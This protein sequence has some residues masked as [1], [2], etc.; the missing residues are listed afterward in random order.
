MN[1]WLEED[2]DMNE[3]VEI[4]VDDDAKLIFPYEVKGGQIPP[5]RDES[6][7]SE[8]PNAESSDSVS[9][10]SEL[11]DEVDVEPEVDV[12]PEATIGTSTEKPYAIR[13]FLRGL[14]EVGESSST[15]DL[16]YVGG[17]APWA[18]RRDLD[19]TRA[20]ARLT[21]A[22]LGTCQ[23][24][25]ALLKSK[26]KIEEKERE[27]LNHDLENVEHA[28]GNVLERVSVLESGEN[29]T[30]KKKLDE[31]E[32]KLVWARMER[33]IAERSLHESRVWNKRFYLDMV[34][35][36]AVPKPPSDKEDTERPRKKSNKS[37]SDGTEGPSE[38]RGPPS[39]S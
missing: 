27:I 21:E 7:D 3:D 19:A 11:E 31:T 26:D 24:E 25:I 9:S 10:N 13:N 32:T 8:P 15:R 12:A 22:E 39:D 37:S 36:G 16:S 2:D 30:L 14:Y 17:L 6:S 38:P 35:I 23:A 28:L 1:G 18:L 4:E 33:D 34:R 20:R 29:D 5:P